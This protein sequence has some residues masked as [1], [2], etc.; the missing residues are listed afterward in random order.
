MIMGTLL[1]MVYR[2]FKLDL[3]RSYVHVFKETT[4][5]FNVNLS[6]F[7]DFILCPTDKMLFK[8]KNKKIRLICWMSSKLKI[9]T[10][11]R[12]SGIF[13]IDFDHSSIVF[14]LL[15]LNKYL[16]EGCESQVIV[17]WKYKKRYI[18]FVIKVAI[19]IS[20]NDLSLHQTE[21]SYKD[22]TNVS[23]LDLL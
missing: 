18:C 9:D 22:I 2:L 12:R 19:P 14:L 11:W 13:I 8:V 6:L 3:L 20:F 17:F 23:A 10:A 1:S 4:P 21:T 15:T 5:L 16:P 7:V